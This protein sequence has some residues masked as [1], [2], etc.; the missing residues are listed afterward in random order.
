MPP[1]RLSVFAVEA[2]D[3]VLCLAARCDELG[4]FDLQQ[5]LLESDEFVRLSLKQ[6]PNVD[7]WTALLLQRAVREE[8]R[9]GETELVGRPVLSQYAAMAR[10]LGFPL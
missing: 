7:I 1:T 6:A 10:G 3:R 2:N 9:H 5:R 4:I 8:K